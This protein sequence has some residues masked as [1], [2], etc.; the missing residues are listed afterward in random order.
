MRL[1]VFSDEIETK[2]CVF[3]NDIEMKRCVFPD[4]AGM[5]R[6]VF[7]DETQRNG[8]CSRT[9]GRDLGRDE[10]LVDL[11]VVEGVRERVLLHVNRRDHLKLPTP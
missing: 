3:P 7:P 9:S 11:L 6:R 4:E 2:P 8:A 5:K 10:E 1:N